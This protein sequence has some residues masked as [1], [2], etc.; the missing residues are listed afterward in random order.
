MKIGM[1]L[2]A[3]L[4]CLVMLPVSTDAQTECVK[5]KF[6]VDGKE[7]VGQKIKILI[8]ADGQTIEPK[9]LEGGFVVPPEISDYQKIE[10]RFV[11]GEYD[12]LFSSLTKYH[13]DSE[14][15]VGVNNPPFK[16]QAKTSV[17]Q[18][19]KELKLIY[20]IEFHPKNAENTKWITRVYK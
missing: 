20:Y 6:E 2:V 13:F 12:L 18:D 17:P 19:G 10:I 8:N 15:L 9:F 1:I 16:E 5:I 14:W 7:V 4:I 3:V 11:S